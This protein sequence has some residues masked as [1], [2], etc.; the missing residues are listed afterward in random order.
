MNNDLTLAVL[1]M[2]AY[3]D[4]APSVELQLVT[5]TAPCN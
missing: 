1:L 4:T 3:E 5:G 2:A